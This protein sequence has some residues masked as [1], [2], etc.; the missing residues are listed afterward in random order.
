MDRQK[1]KKLTKE[2]KVSFGSTLNKNVRKK[3]NIKYIDKRSNRKSN[4]A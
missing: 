3:Y 4:I 2:P 1:N